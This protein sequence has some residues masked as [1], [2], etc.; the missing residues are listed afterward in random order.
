[1]S[2]PQIGDVYLVEQPTAE[3]VSEWRGKTSSEVQSC[4]VCG[5]WDTIKVMPDL[6]E[7]KIMRCKCREVKA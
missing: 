4:G 3:E 1:M 2:D 7:E 6:P 5:E